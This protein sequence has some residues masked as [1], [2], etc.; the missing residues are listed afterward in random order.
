M[1]KKFE[2]LDTFQDF[3]DY[4]T[5]ACTKSVDE[6]IHLWQISYMNKYPELLAKQIQCYKTENTGWQDI[7]LRLFPTFPMR[8]QLMRK[9]RNNILASYEPIC[10]QASEKLGFDFNIILVIYVGIGC[11]A[12]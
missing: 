1:R 12:G 9:A 10:T 11:G 3:S 6:Q 5:H 7:A 8:L 4:W 2:I